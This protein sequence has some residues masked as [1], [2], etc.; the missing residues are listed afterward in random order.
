MSKKLY[1][2][3]AVPHQQIPGAYHARYGRP[4]HTAQ[5]VHE[6]DRKKVFTSMLEA[7]LGAAKALIADLNYDVC[8]PR[9]AGR[10]PHHGKVK[11]DPLITDIDKV[12]GPRP[13]VRLPR[14]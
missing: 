5:W 8:A 14:Q 2:V 1:F 3:G 4:G 9:L 7:E 12:F 11:P 13:G 6:Q 10:R